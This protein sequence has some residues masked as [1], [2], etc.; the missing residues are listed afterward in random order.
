[1]KQSF[2]SHGKLLLTSEYLVLDGAEALALP[3]KKGQHLK[4]TRSSASGVSWKSILHD[5]TTWIDLHFK[6][7]LS[8]NGSETSELS[9]RLLDILIAAQN[10]NP[11]FLNTRDGYHV[12]SILEFPRDW[13]LGSSST[14]ITNIALWAEVNPYKL[15]EITFGGSG[16]DIA[17]ATSQTPIIYRKTAAK[18][19]VTAVDF[20]PSF[21]NQLYFIHLNRKQNS[22]ESIQHYRN[23]DSSLL[24][25]EVSHF[26]NIT[27]EIKKCSVLSEFE[28]LLGQHEERLSGIL[29]T[30][31]IKNQLFSNYPHLIKSLGGWGGDFVLVVGDDSEMAYFKKKGYDTIIPYDEM[32]L[33]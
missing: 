11:A 22:R 19:I 26:S 3:T 29:K 8:D 14:L 4:I 18:P 24:S 20:N 30:P 2:Y 32:I 10:L 28:S 21:K 31:T 17:C 7:P 15:L 1:M 23:L 5:G 25:N 6:L 16:Y 9:Q 27:K 33:N 13:G 12:E